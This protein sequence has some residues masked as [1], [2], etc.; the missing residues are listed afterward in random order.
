MIAHIT[1]RV[2]ERESERVVIDVGGIG[3][4]LAATR[5]A[6]RAASPGEVVT[7]QTHLHVREDL[8]Q[9]FAF[10]DER[11]RAFFRLLLGVA[12]IGPK[13][14]MA[15]VSAFPPEQ[16]E[17]AIASQ[18]VAL[19]ASVSGVGRK[20]AQRICIDLKDRVGVPASV[21]IAAANRSAAV[22]VPSGAD[23]DEPFYAAR[24]ALIAFGY[25]LPDAEAALDG[26]DG[27]ADER[28]KAAL[29]RLRGAA[30]R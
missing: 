23:L 24:E 15:I 13:L 16:L 4:E 10:A 26:V 29:Q 11:E 27:S 3:F 18:D 20:T 19:L 14:A 2:V 1:G 9:L 28:V 17:R 5:L 12:G 21:S 25:A 8:L 22:R 7:L 30:A 6:E